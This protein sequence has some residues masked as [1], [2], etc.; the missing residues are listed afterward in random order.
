MS[1]TPSGCVPGITCCKPGGA[2]YV[3]PDI[4]SFGLSSEEFCARLLD[5]AGVAAAWGTSFGEHGE[6]HMRL[7]Y[8]TSLDNIKE[9]V[10]RIEQFTR[11]L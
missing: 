4:S 10:R 11:G 8:A 6:G 9:A 7:S 2:F 1:D 5:E 3:F